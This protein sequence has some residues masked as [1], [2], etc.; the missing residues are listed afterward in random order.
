ML[1]TNRTFAVLG[2]C[3]IDFQSLVQKGISNNNLK[4]IPY[5][6]KN[7]TQNYF[8]SVLN[9]SSFAHFGNCNIIRRCVQC[10]GGTDVVYSQLFNPWTIF[11]V[12]VCEQDSKGG[13]SNEFGEI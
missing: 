13:M 9:Q 3:G 2:V 6:I 4:S 11:Q 12:L 10:T 5:G 1:L 8:E 7:I